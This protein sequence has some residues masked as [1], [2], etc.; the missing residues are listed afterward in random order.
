MYKPIEPVEIPSMKDVLLGVRGGPIDVGVVK[1]L[2]EEE[3]VVAVNLGIPVRD[4][5]GYRRSHVFY[6]LNEK[7]VKVRHNGLTADLEVYVDMFTFV[8]EREVLKG[9]GEVYPP[10]DPFRRDWGEGSYYERF[11]MMYVYEGIVVE[12]RSKMIWDGRHGKCITRDGVEV[13]AGDRVGVVRGIVRGRL[14]NPGMPKRTYS[15]GN[16]GKTRVA[17]KYSPAVNRD[18]YI[19]RIESWLAENYNASMVPS[20]PINTTGLRKY[21]RTTEAG[22][23]SGGSGSSTGDI[24]ELVA[25]LSGNNFIEWAALVTTTTSSSS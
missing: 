9:E 20:K 14:D 6:R 19:N 5:I 25:V 18:E 2:E 22:S 15:I 24:E 8:Q 11:T 4:I 7:P 1:N 13:S 17:S 12:E 10:G 23:G 21:Y 3:S 16:E